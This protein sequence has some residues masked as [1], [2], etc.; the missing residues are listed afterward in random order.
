MPILTAFQF[1][2]SPESLDLPA[3]QSAFFLSFHASADPQTGKPWCPDVRAAMPYLEEAFSAD[4]APSVAFIGVG[5]KPEWRDLSNVYRTK[6]NVSSVPTLVRYERVDETVKEV[7][8]L[9]EGEIMDRARLLQ[10]IRT[11]SARV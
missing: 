2:G 10:F 3:D 9:V 8:R 4:H 1:P 5:Q 7:G 6:W 11:R